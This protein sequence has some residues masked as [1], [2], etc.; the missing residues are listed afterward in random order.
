M[1][2]G[3]SHP[4]RSNNPTPVVRAI[5][6]LI[7]IHLLPQKQNREKAAGGYRAL[8]TPYGPTKW[9]FLGT[10]GESVFDSLDSIWRSGAT[11]LPAGG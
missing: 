10:F 1:F 2:R 8:S 9:R 4:V 11:S 7:V 3:A 5:K 6:F